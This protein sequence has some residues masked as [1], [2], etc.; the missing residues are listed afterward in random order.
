[1]IDLSWMEWTWQ[2]AT[3][4]IVLALSLTG[5]TIWDMR[6]PSVKT[7]GV[8]PVAFTRGERFF[9]SVMILFSVMLLWIA[10]TNLTLWWGLVISALVIFLFVRFG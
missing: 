1:M 3:F 7:K 9:V 10:L 5:M 6:D 8:L 2:T 4:F